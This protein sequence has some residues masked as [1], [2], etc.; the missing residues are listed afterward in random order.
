[1][2]GTSNAKTVLASACV[3]MVCGL[4]V[5]TVQSQGGKT[6]GFSE[7]A[8]FLELNDTDGDL[9]I[10]ASIDGGV[11]TRLMISG[12][13]GALL[14]I[15]SM[16]NLQVQGLTQ[17]AFESAEPSFEDLPPADFFAR[18]PA[19]TYLIQALAQGGGMFSGQ[20]TLSHVLAAPPAN[21][22]LSGLAAP[23][24][25]DAKPLPTLVPPVVIDW[26]PVTTSHSQIGASG[27]VTIRGYQVFVEG[28][29]ARFSMD[30]PDDVTEVEVP[31]G[32]MASGK[33]FKFEI[34]A[35]TATGNNTAVESC[36]RIH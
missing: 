4:L 23:E 15:A 2:W 11:W 22:F 30:L 34:I 26:D 24:S 7:A 19:G 31:S 12:P 18:F 8:V 13:N 20:A 21:I 33:I 32:V 27:P 1:M 28:D 16:N 9:G 35:R 3:V 6:Q 25:C 10:H 17:L 14:D 5:G 36:F 29:Q